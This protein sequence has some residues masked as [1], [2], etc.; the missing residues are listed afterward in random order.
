[1]ERLR[2]YKFKIYPAEEPKLFFVQSFGCIRKVYNLMLEDRMKAY[3]ET[4]NDSSKKTSFPTP[5][6]YKQDFPF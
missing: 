1:M 2:A 5:T 4:K 3:E 6:K